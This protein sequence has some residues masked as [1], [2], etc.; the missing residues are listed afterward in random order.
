MLYLLFFG[1]N[2][3]DL[4]FTRLIRIK[5]KAEVVFPFGINFQRTMYLKEFSNMA[6]NTFEIIKEQSRKYS[7]F[8][9]Q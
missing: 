9:L 2:K 3:R 7:R 8:N 1:A 4:K 5:E 6:S